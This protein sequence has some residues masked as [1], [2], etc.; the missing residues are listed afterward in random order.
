MGP[1]ARDK[2]DGEVCGYE[3]KHSQTQKRQSPGDV[4][5][6]NPAASTATITN[7]TIVFIT[8]LLVCAATLWPSVD[9]AA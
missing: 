9:N 4:K 1:A 2:D 7:A 8:V 3:Q 6:R 5:P